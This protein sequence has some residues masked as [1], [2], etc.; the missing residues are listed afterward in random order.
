[1]TGDDQVAARVEAELR[2]QGLADALD[3]QI[4]RQVVALL[5]AGADD[6]IG[7]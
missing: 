3:D 6:G 1:M 2:A 7:S 5:S 4:T